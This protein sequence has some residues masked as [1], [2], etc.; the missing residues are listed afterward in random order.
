[1]PDL[2]QRRKFRLS[3][4]HVL[5]APPLLWLL[6][7]FVLPVGIVLAFGF[8]QSSPDGLIVPRFTLEHFRNALDPL[9]LKV[10]GRSLAY[11]G[12][13][14]LL[15]LLLAY[16]A[17]CFMA[18]SPPR[19]QKILLFL[20]FLPLWTNL[21]VRLYAL[22]ILLSDGGLV[23]Q[24]LLGLSIVEKPLQLLNNSFAV[25]AGFVYWN[26]P[27]LVP[28][29]FASLDRMN[30]SLVEASMDLGA[31]RLA[32]FRNVLLPQ[33]LPGVA[34]GATLCFIPTLGCFI[35]P[36]VL[37]GTGTT[38]V[39]NLVVAQFQQGRNW[40]FGSAIATLLL[41]VVMAGICLYLR[42]YDPT[43]KPASEDA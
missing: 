19:R 3:E 4:L 10:L 5:L 15:A 32:T 42:Y 23:N 1:M 30:V 8:F 40:P 12:G 24:A 16:P 11:A 37:G 22:V 43:R 18:F 31:G 17:A 26:L 14:T 27:F 29:I 6:V 13:S 35:V 28:P 2:V 33:S 7:F 39:G 21:L 34:A 38:M 41:L 9:Y 25:L 20:V 36:D